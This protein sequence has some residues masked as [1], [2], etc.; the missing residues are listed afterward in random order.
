MAAPQTSGISVVV[1]GAALDE[2]FV[3]YIDQLVVDDDLHRPA[4][5]SITLNDPRRNIIPRSGLKPGAEVEIS[6]VA[7]GNTDDRPLLKGDVV[8]VECDYDEVARQAVVRGYSAAHRLHRGRR[9]R[10]FQDSTD[11][12]IVRQVAEE[13]GLEIGEIEATSEVH[14]HITQA[15]LTDWDFLMSRARPLGLDL[16]IADGALRFGKR[17][18]VDDAPPEGDAEAD[19]AAL[20]PRNLIFGLNLRKLHGTLSAAA[21]VATVEVRGWD[22]DRKEPVTASAPAKTGA[23]GIKAADPARLAGLF[24]DPGFVDVVT[25]VGSDREAEGV[26]AALADRIGSAFAEAEG[27]A[28]GSTALRAGVAVRISRVGED[29]DG[30]YVLSNVRHC[31]DKDGYRTQFTVS[32]HHDRSLLGLISGGSNGTGGHASSHTASATAG[33]VRGIVSD[34][35]DPDKLG[36]VKVKLPW[37]DDSFSSAWAPV[38]QLGAGPESGTFFLPAYGD[39]V[40]VGFLHGDINLPVVVG[41]LF[42]SIDKPPTYEHFL[43]DGKV[44]GRAIVSRRGHEIN[45]YDA[46]DKLGMTLHVVNDSRLPV[47]SIGLNATDN[48]LVIQ[49]EGNVDVQAEGEIN[50][51]GKKVTVQAQGDLVLKGG[52]VKIN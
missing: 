21:Q 12:E 10:V 50:I 35:V 2:Q 42:N 30:T 33:L 52:M 31:I 28:I 13:A 3:A 36:R 20:N 23:A 1:D 17:G 14:E 4:M 19:P 9:T 37:L 16:T 7:L 18:T 11:D 5:F 49:S 39:E 22:P 51:S 15:N 26:A 25:P 32:G 46:D 43:D 41:G 6:I 8:T 29:F 24:G 40:L 34:T 47:V 44:V 27:T 45:L 48:K 38:M